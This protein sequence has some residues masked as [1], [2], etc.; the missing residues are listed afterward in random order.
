MTTAVLCQLCHQD[1]QWHREHKPKHKFVGPDDDPRLVMDV[2]PQPDRSVRGDPVLRLALVKAG[3][4]TDGDIMEAEIL[5][6]T[7]AEE[8]MAV[9]VEDGQYRLLSIEDWILHTAAGRL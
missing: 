8:G 3:V 4:V 5:I 1:D 6:R 7:A 2:P 9:V